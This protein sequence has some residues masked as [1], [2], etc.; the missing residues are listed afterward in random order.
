MD[1]AYA[2]RE[3]EYAV[4]RADLYI[5]ETTTYRLYHGYELSL[6][7]QKGIPVLLVS[8]K[9]FRQYAISGVKNKLLTMKTYKDRK[10]LAEIVREFI[11]ANQMASEDLTV[12]TPIDRVLLTY[13]DDMA[14]AAG[15]T[16]GEALYELAKL[17]MQVQKITAEKKM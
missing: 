16:K 13:L 2:V 9:S 15:K 10:E 17:G 4:A 1:W 6:A 12:Q 7:L 5:A 14:S 3:N 11:A 8:R